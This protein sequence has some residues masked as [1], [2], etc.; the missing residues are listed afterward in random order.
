M[1]VAFL[2]FVTSVV[3]LGLRAGHGER[4]AVMLYGGTLVVG[5][6]FFNAVWAWARRGHHLLDDGLSVPAARRSARR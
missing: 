6:I 4:T 1:N 3:A 5:G 2:P